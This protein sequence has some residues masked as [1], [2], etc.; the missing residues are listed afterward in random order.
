MNS[1]LEILYAHHVQEKTMNFNPCQ[2]IFL[3]LYL[4]DTNYSINTITSDMN[5]GVLLISDHLNHYV[6]YPLTGWLDEDVFQISKRWT[7]I[8]PGRNLKKKYVHDLK[9]IKQVYERNN[10]NII[11][12]L[13]KPTISRSFTN[14]K[15]LR[16]VELTHLNLLIKVDFCNQARFCH[17][18]LFLSSNRYDLVH[19]RFGGYGCGQ[20][21]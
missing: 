18:L 20:V 5:Y 10:K 4:V 15:C 14:L 2:H 6:Y 9:K 7:F 17:V 21:S 8:S 3:S 16:P 12:T 1:N 11:T 13:N 19:P